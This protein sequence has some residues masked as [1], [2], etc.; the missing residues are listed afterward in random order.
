MRDWINVHVS[1]YAVDDGETDV[2]MMCVVGPRGG[3]RST[4]V[5]TL[6]QAR[7]LRAQ[8]DEVIARFDDRPRDR[9]RLYS[10]RDIGHF[11]QEL[12]SIK[13]FC[14]IEQTRNALVIEQSTTSGHLSQRFKITIEDTPAE[15]V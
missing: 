7:T 8:L 3:T 6:E 2:I 13:G 9:I 12:V 5:L 11:L 10:I 1:P 15:P 14:P 4:D